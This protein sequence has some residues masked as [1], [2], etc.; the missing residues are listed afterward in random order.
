MA[1]TKCGFNDVPGGLKGCDSLQLHGPTLIVSIGFDKDFNPQ[2]PKKTAVP[3]ITGVPA[4]V[5]T[6]ASESC[7][8]NTLA[9]QLNLP[10]VDKRT[11]SGVG[12]KHEVPV[13]MA[14][15]AIP[16]LNFMIYGLFAGVDLI[17]GG[18]RHQALIGRTFL[19]GFRMTYEGDTGT[20]TISS[21]P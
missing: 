8:D 4:L 3:G 18:Q 12:G 2:N 6:G 9:Q 7:I 17:K 15:I 1:N 5:D 20:V 13:Y 19:R 16:S 10:I 11:I 21:A 14:Q